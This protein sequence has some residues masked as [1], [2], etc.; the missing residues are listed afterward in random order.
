[1]TL[2]K[3]DIVHMIASRLGRETPPMSTGSTEPRIIFDMINNELGL[4]I[5]PSL[6]KIE[7]ARA[8]VESTGEPWAPG[9][10]SRG[11]TVTLSGLRAVHEAVEFY[12][13]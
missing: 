8:I 1:M 10:E 7:M 12:T 6:S 2:R 13:G 11:G 4:G 9:F 5:S 3:G